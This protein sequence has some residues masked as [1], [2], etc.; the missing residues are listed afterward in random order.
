MENI[1]NG[2]AGRGRGWGRMLRF[3]AIGAAGVAVNTLVLLALTQSFGLA[4]WQASP[5][6]TETAII[7]NFLL[8]D[9]WTFRDLRAGSPIARFVRYNGVA[10]GGMLITVAVLSLLTRLADVEL[11]PANLVAVAVATAWNYVVNSRWTWGIAR[12]QSAR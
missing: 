2:R 1:R 6:A 4:A 10:L 11:L 7:S 9:F 5:L 3:G 12:S 8:N